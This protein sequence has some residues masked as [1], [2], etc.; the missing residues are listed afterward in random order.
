MRETD[1]GNEATASDRRTMSNWAAAQT[2]SRVFPAAL[3]L[4]SKLYIFVIIESH[5]QPPIVT[6]LEIPRR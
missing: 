6:K 1:G 5:G 2:R 4:P 3:A